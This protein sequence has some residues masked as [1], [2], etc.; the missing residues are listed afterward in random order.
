M[1]ERDRTPKGTDVAESPAVR[2]APSAPVSPITDDDLHW[3]NEGTHS[4]LYEKLGAHPDQGGTHFAVWAP[5]AG[6]VSLMGD[7]NGWNRGSHRLHARAGSGIW[8]GFLRSVGPG[9]VYKFHVVPRSDAPGM[10][11]ADPFAFFCET[12]P[13]TGSIVWDLSYE[14]GDDSWMRERGRRNSLRAPM[15]TYEVHLG[16]WMRGEGDRMPGYRE[17]AERLVEYLEKL[18]FTHVEFLPVM[19]H[20]FY[21][22]W[23]YQTT[24]Y[25]A[26][27]SR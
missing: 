2:A 5:N 11:K 1:T 19:E 21:G 18:N 17:L 3:F 7:F 12:P 24:G 10:D 26:P 15:S 16:S 4:H 27:T 13:R 22:S 8:E 14:W 20:P 9:A 25:F 6:A 23:G